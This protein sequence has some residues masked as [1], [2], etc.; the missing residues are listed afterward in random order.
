MTRAPSVF[1]G[2]SLLLVPGCGDPDLP[3]V[4][5]P[6]T[7]SEG[8]S[9]D[10][11]TGPVAEP[12]AIPTY[13][14]WRDTKA[15]IDAKCGGCHRPDDIAP[16]PLTTYEHVVAVA[17]VLPASLEAE[18][19]PP[20]PPAEGCQDYAHS[21]ALDEADAQ[22][23]LTWLDEGA[24][25]GDPA[26]APAPD[27]DQEPTEWS[28]TIT[29]E[30]AE[31]YTPVT[32][33]DDHRCFVLPWPQDETRYIT[34][35]RVVPGNREIV[36]HVIMFNGGAETVADLQAMD[37]A[38]PGPGYQCFG[39]TGTR[40]NWVASWAPGGGTN[41]LPEGT[42]IRIEPGSMMVLQVHY[43]TLSSDPEPDRSTV[44]LVLSEQVERPALTVPFTN[45][46]WITGG[47]PMMIPAG[48]PEVT[49]AVE[50]SPQD[51]ILKIQLADLELDPSDGFTVHSIGTHMHYL[52]T[53]GTI[54]VLRDAGDEDCMLHID[55]WDFNWQEGYF[56][57]DPV[58]I[59]AQ[60]RIR[61][62]CTWDNSAANQPTIDGEVLEPRD[63]VWGEGTTDE[64]CLGVMYVTAE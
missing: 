24:P 1:L 11:T 13:T 10:E 36:H 44:E 15:I 49:H 39:G 48:D 5:S 57:R 46:Q 38:D 40:A 22:V 34:G 19:M 32:E 33:P 59:G 28:P 23:L 8:P 21:R 18:T 17:P 42:G 27:P 55:D 30:M 62:S 14:Y 50:L 43:N 9:D 58:R 54:S 45:F 63:L 31:P 56:F 29:V 41:M 35:Y 20:W 4:D 64:M 60:D 2:C 6:E 37:D 16:F 7:E 3:S 26:D 52:G 53:S 12:E 61:L 51:P 25:Q 47:E